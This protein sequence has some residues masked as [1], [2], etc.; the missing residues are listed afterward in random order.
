MM[1]TCFISCEL[2][3]IYQSSPDHFHRFLWYSRVLVH[4][5]WW[6][7]CCHMF[8]FVLFVTLHL[9]YYP[10]VS[11]ERLCFHLPFHLY[12]TSPSHLTTGLMILYEKVVGND[13]EF[14]LWKSFL[15]EMAIWRGLSRYQRRQTPGHCIRGPG[16]A[17]LR[18]GNHLPQ[19]QVDHDRL[20]SG[21]CYHW[22]RG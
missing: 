8:Y 11:T 15:Y 12:I 13:Y 21:I 17:W 10:S 9:Q 2:L 3:V 1:Y 7:Y 20:G 22:A 5:Q 6:P 19:V 14:H 16:I 18:F 4:V